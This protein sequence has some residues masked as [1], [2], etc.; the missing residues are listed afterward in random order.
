[1]DLN[2]QLHKHDRQCSKAKQNDHDGI[3]WSCP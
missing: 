2:F 1:M 3:G